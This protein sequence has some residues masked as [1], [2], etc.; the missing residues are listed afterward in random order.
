MKILPHHSIK[1]K[2][3]KHKKCIICGVVFKIQNFRFSERG[4]DGE[5]LV[6]KQ[7][8]RVLKNRVSSYTPRL[9]QVISLD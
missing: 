4:G 5:S 3:G 8:L 9:A 1:I 7:D 6:N 2:D